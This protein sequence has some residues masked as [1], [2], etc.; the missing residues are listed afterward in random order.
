M[1]A[2]I[3]RDGAAKADSASRRLACARCGVA[4]ECRPGGGCWCA[5]E[6][7]RLPMTGLSSDCLC[8]DCLRKAAR[9]IRP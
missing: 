5:E 7:Y 2:A 1:R 4:F 3:E 9:N 6:P 8:P